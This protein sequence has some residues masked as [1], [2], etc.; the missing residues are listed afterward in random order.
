MDYRALAEE[1]LAAMAYQTMPTEEPKQ[2]SVGERG[3]LNYLHYH[4][5][6][7]FAGEISRDLGITTGRTAIALKNLEK[8]G[9]IQRSASETDRRCVVVRITEAGSQAAEAFRLRVL[10]SVEDVLRALGERDAPEYVRLV[11]RIAAMEINRRG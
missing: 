10:D 4:N 9:L 7:A 1:L 11:K 3:I 8:K 6:D 5:N 2:L